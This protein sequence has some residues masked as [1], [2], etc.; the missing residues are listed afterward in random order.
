MMPFFDEEIF[1]SSSAENFR[2]PVDWGC[3]HGRNWIKIFVFIGSFSTAKA[4]ERKTKTKTKKD[5]D[6]YKDK[7]T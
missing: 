4:R 1:N 6:K 7:D 5:K 2:G 3:D